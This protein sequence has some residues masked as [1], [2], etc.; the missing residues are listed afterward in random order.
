MS[1]DIDSVKITDGKAGM[2]VW[3]FKDLG[4]SMEVKDCLPEG[5]PFHPECMAVTYGKNPNDVVK[6]RSIQWSGQFSGSLFDYYMRVFIKRTL[7]NYKFIVTW[8]GG[9]SIV[10]YHII[11]GEV[12]STI[13]MN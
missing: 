7:G 4:Q 12:I 1:Y 6:L 13:D 9:N 8:K 11:D 10:Q 2:K 3:K 5:H